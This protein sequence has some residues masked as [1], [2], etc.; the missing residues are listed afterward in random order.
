MHTLILA[1]E[2]P[3]IQDISPED[4]TESIDTVVAEVMQRYVDHGLEIRV[5]FVAASVHPDKVAHILILPRYDGDGGFEFASGWTM[6]CF[7]DR[8]SKEVKIVRYHDMGIRCLINDFYHD[9]ATSDHDMTKIKRS[10]SRVWVEVVNKEPRS[11]KKPNHY[12]F[13]AHIGVAMEME[14]FEGSLI[15]ATEY[16]TKHESTEEVREF[17]DVS[18][19]KFVVD[20]LDKL[21]NLRY[22]VLLTKL[23]NQ[24]PIA[25]VRFDGTRIMG[26]CFL[27]MSFGAER[28]RHFFFWI[29]STDSEYQLMEEAMLRAVRQLGE[30][31]TPR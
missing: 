5:G 12:E 27:K 22:I 21:T 24:N 28:L 30:A 19:P 25:I 15:D 9:F 23:T 7:W 31:P 26:A 2:S 13:T 1:G 18:E 11:A 6:F 14:G 20:V 3:E 4:F 10:M 8:R 16:L 17:M 29:T